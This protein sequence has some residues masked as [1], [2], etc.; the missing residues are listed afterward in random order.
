LDGKETGP[1]VLRL[2]PTA[3]V[4]GQVVDSEGHPLKDCVVSPAYD[5]SEIGRL[6]GHGRQAT[7]VATTDANGK[8]TLANLPAGLAVAFHALKPNGKSLGHST[9]TQTLKPGQTLDLGDWKP[10]PK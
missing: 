5:D 3:T 9:P 8:F 1:V 7:A 2:A 10:A 6:L 4:T